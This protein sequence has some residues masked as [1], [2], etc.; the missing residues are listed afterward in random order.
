[1]TLQY[2]TVYMTPSIRNTLISRPSF[3]LVYRRGDHLIKVSIV[4]NHIYS[5]QCIGPKSPQHKEQLLMRREKR[6]S[7]RC[8]GQRMKYKKQNNLPIVY[9]RYR[10]P[11]GY[12][13]DAYTT[14]E[15]V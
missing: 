14:Q 15:P 6:K 7:I 13:L 1:M 5:I 3:P 11:E 4:L 2:G 12:I 9:P 10:R 8:A